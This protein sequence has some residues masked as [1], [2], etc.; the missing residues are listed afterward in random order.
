MY[1]LNYLYGYIWF[2]ETRYI[3]GHINMGIKKSFNSS[4]HPKSSTDTDNKTENVLEV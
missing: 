2:G 3:S 1:F 4:H